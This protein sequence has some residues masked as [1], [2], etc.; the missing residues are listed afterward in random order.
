MTTKEVSQRW[1]EIQQDIKNDFLTHITKP[2]LVAIVKKLDL[3]VQGFSKR[4]V[5]KA[6]EPFLKQA[7]TQLIDNTIDLHLFFSS[8]TQPFYQQMED[9]DY[10]TFLLKASLSD[11]P[12]NI[13]KL[14][15]LATLFPEQYKENRD[16]IASNIKN[17]QDALCGFVEPSLTDIL[18]S[19]VEKYDFTRLFK[20]FFNQ[21]EELNGNIL[22]DTFDPD[23]FFTNVYEDLEKS[24]VL[25]LLKDFDLDDFNFSDQDLLFIFKLGLAEA[26][27]HDVEQLK[28]HK[29]TAD[30]ALAERDSFES[31]V[32]QFSKQRLDQSNKIKEKD[33]EIKQLNAQ[34]KK[35]LKTVSLEN[36][37]LR[38]SM[39]KVTIE[40]KQLNQNQEKM[41][42]NLF[43][44][45]D[46]FFFMTRANQSSFNKLI[47]NN[48]IISYDPDT[49]FSEQFKSLPNNRLLFIDA[50]KMTSKLQ[51]TIENH[52]NYKKISYK[53]VSG[54]PETMF[55]QIIFYLEGD[56]SD[57]T[58]K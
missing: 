3:D 38:Q 18:S 52:L 54:A 36:E 10:Q 37:K 6:R 46:Q 8:F 34:H 51:M 11:G 53:F 39:E 41:Q 5:H 20:E 42:F 29:N 48:L 9:Y 26:I 16:Q 23:D 57:E 32:N 47:P 30:K 31:K 49:S 13:D 28:I 55:R 15:L 14:L 45:E 1:L 35:E 22:P 4:N 44:D 19:N 50:N 40:N 56:S 43:N 21:H 33:K 12:T 17:G 25:N 27:Y 2:E 24:Y 58:N 7:V